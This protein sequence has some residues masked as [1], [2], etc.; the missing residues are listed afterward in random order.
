MG[1][2]FIPAGIMAAALAGV[3][4]APAARAD[5]FYKGKELTLIIGSGTGGGYDAYGR[6]IGKHLVKHL[7]GKPVFVARN[8]PGAGG[9]RGFSYIYNAAAKD[10]TMIG[11]TLRTV[12]IDPILHSHE[13]FDYDST[14]INWLGSANNEV[15]TCLVWHTAPAHTI[16]QARKTELLFG[17]TGPSSNETLQ[18]LLLNAVLGTKIRVVHGYKSSSEVMLAAERG[19][20]HGRCGFGWDSVVSRYKDVYDQKKL[21]IL[22]QLGLNKHPDIPDVPFIM[23]LVKTPEDRQIVELF[24]GPNEMGR[25]FFAPPGIPKARAAELRRAFDATMTDKAMLADADKANMAIAP[26]TGQQVEELM[27]RMYRTPAPVRKRAA[28]LIEQGSAGATAK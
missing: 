23:D 17:S 1:K 25:P 28:A 2:V 21:I 5:D 11:T 4:S 24:V 10:G 20:L 14:K 26:M 19:E 3:L 22:V 15:S 16:E 27:L 9:R 8:M 6:L 7:P 18:A 12:P 13:S